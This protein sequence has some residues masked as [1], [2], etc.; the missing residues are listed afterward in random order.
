LLSA[1][2]V[3]SA[4]VGAL[5]SLSINKGYG[6]FRGVP[7]LRP[8]EVAQGP[9]LYPLF[10]KPYLSM[11][12]FSEGFEPTEYPPFYRSTEK[13]VWPDL[14]TVEQCDRLTSEGRRAEV[15]K[16]VRPIERAAEA[17]ICGWRFLNDK[18]HIAVPGFI[19][20]REAVRFI[21][22]R[23]TVAMAQGDWDAAR[24]D[25][26]TMIRFGTVVGSEGVLVQRMIGVAMHGIGTQCATLAVAVAPE[27][28]LPRFLEL[29]RSVDPWVWI[30]VD[31]EALEEAEPC[32]AWPNR[33][34]LADI[35][36]P[37]GMRAVTVGK[38]SVAKFRLALLACATRRHIV[39]KGRLPAEQDDLREYIPHPPLNPFTNKDFVM[40]VTPE[41]VR[42]TAEDS[43][44]PWFDTQ[45]TK[46]LPVITIKA[47]G[48]VLI[49]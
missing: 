2:L 11:L 30:L 16:Y 4:I 29:L 26:R 5:C 7:D 3:V 39:E 18:N 36:F 33:L 8:G 12:K 14:P 41:Y 31:A 17:D 19:N 32:F 10:T 22:A 46:Y 9:I 35:M 6:T 43:I 24:R 49:E 13:A 37:G 28:E 25:I 47:S 45:G 44:P 40:E 1:I 48:E 21:S 38:V 15:Q 34:I 42:F 23:S 27:E 20:I